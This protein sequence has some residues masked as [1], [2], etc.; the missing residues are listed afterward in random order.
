MS[1]HRLNG[2]CA[3]L[4]GLD[5]DCNLTPESSRAAGR[6]SAF[7]WKAVLLLFKRKLQLES[8]LPRL[9]WNELSAFCV[10]RNTL[11]HKV[12]LGSCFSG[13]T[14][15]NHVYQHAYYKLLL[16]QCAADM[17][18]LSHSANFLALCLLKGLCKAFCGSRAV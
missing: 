14:N 10:L 3:A 7:S 2:G 4:Q 5:N 18:R 17:A 6:V 16:C 15:S 9:L 8:E 12:R 1:H 13:Y 11:A